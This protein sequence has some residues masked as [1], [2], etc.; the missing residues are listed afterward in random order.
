LVDQ[1]AGEDDEQVFI[2]LIFSEIGPKTQADMA[3]RAALFQR[4]LGWYDGGNA[5]DSR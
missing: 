3:T 1:P 4:R 5:G 2:I